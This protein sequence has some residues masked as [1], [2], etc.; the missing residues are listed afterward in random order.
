MKYAY[1]IED[2]EIV[3]RKEVDDRN[4]DHTDDFVNSLC[5]QYFD[6]TFNEDEAEGNGWLYSVSETEMVF[7][8]D[9]DTTDVEKLWIKPN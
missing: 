8:T 2:G 6:D 1:V 3:I 4:Y 9:I 7:V 5:E